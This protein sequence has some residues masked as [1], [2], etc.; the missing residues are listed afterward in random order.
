SFVLS[1]ATEADMPEI[2]AVQYRS[3]EKPII[4]RELVM[5]CLSPEDLPKFVDKR[6]RTMRE[7]PTDIWIKVVDSETNKIVAASNW[8]LYLGPETSMKRR[9]MEVPEWLTGDHAKAAHALMD[10]MN[11]IKIRNNPQPFLHTCFT[12]PAFWRRGIGSKMLHWGCQVA[13]QLSL[14]AWVEASPEGNFL[15]KRFG[16]R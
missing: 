6:I 2:I 5:G 9:A 16:F 3:F 10:P 14:A 7:D 15:Y 12:D 13:D 8:K 4:V 11:E 1:R